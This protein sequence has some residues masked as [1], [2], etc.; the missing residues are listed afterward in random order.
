M[1]V[2]GV[3]ITPG[4]PDYS[5]R[6]VASIDS[7]AD[8]LVLVLNGADSVTN[9]WAESIQP[10]ALIRRV[11]KVFAPENLGVAGATN[12][13]LFETSD[14]P[15]WFIS[16]NDIKLAPG[17]LAEMCKAAKSADFSVGSLHP[18]MLSGI[19][20]HRDH[21]WSA[22]VLLRHV[23]EE[24]GIWDENLWPAYAED[25][26]FETRLYGGGFRMQRIPSAHVFH[27]PV[28]TKEYTSG[29][30][31]ARTENRDP[32]FIQTL[33]QVLAADRESYTALK[34]SA[35]AQNY[36]ADA[37]WHFRSNP[38]MFRCCKPM[39]GISTR[40]YHGFWVLDPFRRVC[41]LETKLQQPASAELKSSQG[42]TF[43]HF[44]N[45]FVANFEQGNPLPLDVQA[46][47][48]KLLSSWNGADSCQRFS[49]CVARFRMQPQVLRVV[50]KTREKLTIMAD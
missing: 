30:E 15:F 9:Q 44:D 40:F 42:S 46:L 23:L 45:Q 33:A 5:E 18:I 8:T 31:R 29:T 13:I 41:I 39:Y 11:I 34:F 43:C 25:G 36:N 26:D 38:A 24:V 49:D 6:F 2:I 10:N 32:F 35:W 16:N 1:P 21:G 28:A 7:P 47:R 50:S 3:P 20:P 17:A 14:A 27:G 37:I 12:R 48:T 22:F 4:M 19:F